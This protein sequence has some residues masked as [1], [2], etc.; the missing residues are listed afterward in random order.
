MTAKLSIDDKL[1]AVDK[2][3]NDKE[4]AM[5]EKNDMIHKIVKIELLL[6]QKNVENMLLKKRLMDT[7]I[8]LMNQKIDNMKT[9]EA[10]RLA[11]KRDFIKLMEKK[12]K[13]SGKW[14][15]CPESGEIKEGEV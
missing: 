3:L 13:L 14:G 12:H 8:G 6:E 11:E 5:L 2:R 9:V 10:A 15:Y 7:E 4:L 1:K